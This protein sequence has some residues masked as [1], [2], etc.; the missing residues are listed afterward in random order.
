MNRHT[1]LLDGDNIRHGL[2]KDL[3]FDDADRVENARRLAEVA[4]LMTDAG[5]IVI[6]SSI[7]PFTAER[8][9]ARDLIA[10]GE[11]VEVFVD[12]PLE[13]A[14][15]RDAKGLYARARAGELTHFTGVNSPYEAPTAAE[16]RID[17]LTT[18][19]KDAAAEIIARLIP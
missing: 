11:F 14:E 19:P 12:L 2:S 8:R 16:V 17:A 6:V 15:K 18:S 4:K 3:G 10:D 5:L 13:E 1:F 9:M 7:S